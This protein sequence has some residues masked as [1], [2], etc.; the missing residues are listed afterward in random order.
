MITCKGGR[1]KQDALISNVFSVKLQYYHSRA[2][3]CQFAALDRRKTQ[4]RGSGFCKRTAWRQYQSP[5]LGPEV[6]ASTIPHWHGPNERSSPAIALIVL[7]AQLEQIITQDPKLS[8]RKRTAAS[9]YSDSYL[10][11]PCL[12]FYPLLPPLK[13]C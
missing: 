7:L 10:I 2:G 11:E 9:L 5:A 6:S 13:K 3:A 4:E 1:Q 12:A 8:K